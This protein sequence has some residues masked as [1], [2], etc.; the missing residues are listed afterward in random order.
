MVFTVILLDFDVFAKSQECRGGGVGSSVDCPV[1]ETGAENTGDEIRM[2]ASSCEA[3]GD[4]ATPTETEMQHV[5][6]AF[7]SAEPD[8]GPWQCPTCIICTS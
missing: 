2:G 4:G 6:P 5:L 1:S 7:L 8:I 3:T